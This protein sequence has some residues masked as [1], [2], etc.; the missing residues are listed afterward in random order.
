[1][2][3]GP[4][5]IGPTFNRH[6]SSSDS[7]SDYVGR[8]GNQW[9]KTSTQLLEFSESLKDHKDQQKMPT[10]PVAHPA[11]STSRKGGSCRVEPRHLLAGS[12][13]KELS[14]YGCHPTVYATYYHTVTI[15][16]HSDHSAYYRASS[17]H[18][19]K[20]FSS[21]GYLRMS[22]RASFFGAVALQKC[23][24]KP[25]HYDAAM[26]GTSDPSPDPLGRAEFSAM[27]QHSASLSALIWGRLPAPSESKTT[28]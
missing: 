16:F 5:S 3:V 26:L 1:M 9:N 7:S 12:I 25:V 13:W 24:K 6:N 21:W 27:R 28:K 15:S 8:S 19:L 17:Y 4:F 18:G 2:S 20:T 23:R 22:Q 14:G 10:Q 11:F